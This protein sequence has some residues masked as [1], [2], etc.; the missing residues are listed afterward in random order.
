MKKTKVVCRSGLTGEQYR[1]RDSY[2]NFE[3]FKAFAEMY[4]IHT[5]LGYKTPETAWRAN[6]LVQSSVEPRDLCKVL[7]SGKRVYAKEQ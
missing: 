7:K 1:L 6:P 5:R 4:G 2:Q 3:E